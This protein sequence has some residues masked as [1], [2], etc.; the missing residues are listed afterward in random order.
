MLFCSPHGLLPGFFRD[1]I[2]VPQRFR[3]RLLY[4]RGRRTSRRD[5]N[6]NNKEGGKN[7]LRTQ[8]Q[9]SANVSLA[10]LGVQQHRVVDVHRG[11]ERVIR[12]EDILED[13]YRF[14]L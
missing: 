10:H 4:G 3:S 6:K 2:R 1:A 12:A 9:P 5:G 13:A 14:P 8:F 7:K 11:N